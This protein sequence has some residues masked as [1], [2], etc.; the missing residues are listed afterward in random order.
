MGSETK[1]TPGP[2][3]VIEGV[4]PIYN[5]LIGISASEGSHI[6]VVAEDRM[7]LPSQWS[8]NA[9]LIAAA[10]DLLEALQTIAD[11]PTGGVGCNPQSFVEIARAALA[12]ATPNT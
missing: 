11:H 5:Q 7:A 2:W 1:H 10:P 4:S 8:A 12:R 9:R 3:K 6:G